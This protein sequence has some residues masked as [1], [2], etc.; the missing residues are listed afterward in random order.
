MEGFKIS[1]NIDTLDNILDSEPTDYFID[2]KCSECG[3]CCTRYLPLSNKEINQIKAFIK[4]KG[5][6][7]QIHC[8]NVLASKAFDMLC[9]FLDDT[10]PNH[11]CTIYK[12]RPLVCKEFTCRN[13]IRGISP[14]NKLLN[15]P[16]KKTDLVDIFFGNK[17]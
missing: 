14:T 17:G 5:I 6:K 7:Q 10:K 12:V 3:N 4:R 13:Y 8:V 1:M 16:R 15:E 2:N 9:P 11:K